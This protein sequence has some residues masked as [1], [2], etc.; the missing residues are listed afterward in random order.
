[1]T[2]STRESTTCAWIRA[3]ICRHDDAIYSKYRKIVPYHRCARI[4]VSVPDYGSWVDRIRA[5][6]TGSSSGQGHYNENLYCEFLLAILGFSFSLTCVTG[7]HFQKRAKGMKLRASAKKIKSRSKEWVKKGMDS[8]SL[9]PLPLLLLFLCT[10]FPPI[11]IFTHARRARLLDFPSPGKWKGNV[12][13]AGY[14]HSILTYQLPMP[15]MEQTVPRTGTT[16]AL[17]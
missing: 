4:A 2:T 14:L 9:Y 15:A 1:M 13:Y 16:S 12:C 7:D 5:E 10:L 6:R 17:Q 8:V 3:Y 11:F